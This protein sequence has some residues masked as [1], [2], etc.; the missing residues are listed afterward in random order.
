[1]TIS[2]VTPTTD[3]TVKEEYTIVGKGGA[4]LAES[5]LKYTR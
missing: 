5:I 2:A 4:D 1:M 3:T